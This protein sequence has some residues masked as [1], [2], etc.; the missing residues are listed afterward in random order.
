MTYVIIEGNVTADA[1]R[2][3]FTSR[4]HLLVVSYVK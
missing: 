3:A 2:R 4:G 1:T